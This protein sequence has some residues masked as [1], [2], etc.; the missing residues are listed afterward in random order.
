L[1]ERRNAT[2][3]W[4]FSVVENWQ[5]ADVAR[6]ARCPWSTAGAFVEVVSTMRAKAP[7]VPKCAD[8]RRE[9]EHQEDD[10]ISP[11]FL[12]TKG[13]SGFSLRRNRIREVL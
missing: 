4:R 11:P 2:A 10:G 8:S 13:S 5:C 3:W 9:S 7:L 6:H 1:P 12:K